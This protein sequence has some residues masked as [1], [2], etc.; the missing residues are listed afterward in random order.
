MVNPRNNE[1]CVE[2]IPVNYSYANMWIIEQNAIS[3]LPKNTT[4]LRKWMVKGLL[5]NR[6]PVMS[7]DSYI[8]T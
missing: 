3:Y 6:Y 5:K 8:H 2:D 1:C 4:A 7:I